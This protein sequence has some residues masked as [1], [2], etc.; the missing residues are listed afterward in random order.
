MSSWI[1]ILLGTIFLGSLIIVTR[2]WGKASAERKALKDSIESAKKRKAIDNEIQ[3]LS[4]IELA[5][6]LRRG[7]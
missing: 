3:N 2:K 4:P 6:R 5:D 1:I 7:M